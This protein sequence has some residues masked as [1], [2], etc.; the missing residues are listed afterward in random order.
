MSKVVAS[1]TE[2]PLATYLV[3]KAAHHTKEVVI[4]FGQ[5][6]S[7]TVDD[8]TG[9]FKVAKHF[10]HKFSL[11]E[12]TGA[13]N[14]SLETE[15]ESCL[16]YSQA[17][18][19]ATTM[20]EAD[21]A[22]QYLDWKLSNRTYI[23]STFHPTLADFCTYETLKNSKFYKGYQTRFASHIPHLV[24]YFNHLDKRPEFEEAN[25][26]LTTAIKKKTSSL[27][28][29]EIQENVERVDPELVEILEA[30][31]DIN[32]P[33]AKVGQVVTRFPPEPSGYLHVGH[34]KAALLNYFIAKKYNGKLILR[35]DDTN[36]AKEKTEFEHAILED[37]KRLGIK[38][39]KLTYSSDSFDIIADYCEKMIK[40]GKAYAENSPKDVMADL[41]KQGLET[42]CRSYTIEESLRLWGEMKKGSVEGKKCCIRAKIDVASPNYTLRDPILFRCKDEVHPRLG[43]KYKAY[44]TYDFTC[45]IVDSIEGVTHAC[46]T[47]EYND[48][49]HQY[50][51]LADA[52]G[53]RKPFIYDFSRLNL[54]YTLMSKR[55]L[56]KFVDEGVADSWRDP[57]FPT[58]QGLMRRGLTIQ[59][60]RKFISGEMGSRS[61][62][63]LD[64][65]KLWAINKQY[66]DPIVPRYT[67]IK[68]N[69]V[70]TVT[71]RNIG[72]EVTTQEN[73]KHPKNE[74]LGKL[75]TWYSNKIYLDYEDGKDLVSGEEVTL[76]Y[77]G[78]LVIVEKKESTN[79]GF[80]IIADFHKEGSV[81]AT[82]KKFTWLAV[83]DK[84]VDVDLIYYN[85]LL[86]K[87]KLTEE[88]EKELD[89]Y[90]NPD[91]KHVYA[92]FGDPNLLGL[93]KSEPIQLERVGYF[94]VEGALTNGKVTLLNTPDGSSEEAK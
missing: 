83:T 59:G 27:E 72:S 63:T 89:K 73:P 13:N 18:L 60:L 84:L 54:S 32:L 94:V 47:S 44:P 91:S 41:R 81:K 36:P 90:L 65:E 14:S 37:L 16:T 24:R 71:I 29:I 2:P 38:W 21:K 57:R 6:T 85:H 42:P 3:A 52:L 4:S 19:S 92:A 86:T 88:M 53:L 28:I 78:N 17:T 69:K 70:C 34:S 93:K 87:P 51:W 40:S 31:K 58:I 77:W 61:A 64:V 75:T 82:K 80:D 48:R 76:R 9:N 8:I 33:G 43:D 56:Q 12:L 49:N 45:P 20:E 1:A 22:F 55:K 68:K 15:I 39:D 50:Y 25:Y 5:V 11:T 66:L 79:G 30:M 7:A 62:A 10:A 67:A 35:F 26:I 74:K 23:C 46:R